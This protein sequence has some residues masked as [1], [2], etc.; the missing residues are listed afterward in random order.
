MCGG[1]GS[2]LLLFWLLVVCFSWVFSDV[3]FCSSSSLVCFVLWRGGG[4]SWDLLKTFV[5]FFLS[6]FG[7]GSCSS[8]K[9]A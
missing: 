2:Y 3:V 7:G 6:F 1:G 9:K 4:D 5:R 8:T